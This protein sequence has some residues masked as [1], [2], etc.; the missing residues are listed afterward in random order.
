VAR[1][2]VTVTSEGATPT[3]TVALLDQGETLATATL[4]EGG[5]V[6]SVPTTE[7]GVGTHALT[8]RYGGDAARAASQDAVTLRVTRA[9]STTTATVRPRPAASPRAVL[10]IRVAAAVAP[11]GKVRVAV[12][13]DGRVT[14]RTVTLDDGRARLVLRG[15]AAGRH[16][17]TATYAGS[18]TVAPSSDRTVLRVTGAGR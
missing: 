3:G 12:R 7:L 15:L 14:T 18:A 2:A 5:A 11:Q 13:H 9:R 6:L 16:S 1:F 17:I 4:A 8:V 10:D